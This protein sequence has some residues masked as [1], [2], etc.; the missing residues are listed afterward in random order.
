MGWNLLHQT[1][2]AMALSRSIK[3]TA[4][5]LLTPVLLAA[6]FIALFGWNWLRAPVEQMTL[7]K[8]GRQLVIGGDIKVKLGWPR[9]HVQTGAVTFANPPWSSEKQMLSAAALDITIDLSQLF[10]RHIVLPEVR[11]EHPVIFLEQGSAGRKNWLL[12]MN[13][14][15]DST[16]IRIDRLTL[17]QGQLGYDDAA[18]KTHIRAELSSTSSTPDFSGLTF[19]AHGQYK[20]LALKAQGSGGPVLGLRDESSP[21]PLKA[22]F[23]VGDTG[24]KLSGSITSL[25][26]FSALDLQLAVR[27]KNLAQLFPL[28]GIAFPKTNAYA[29]DGHLQHSGTNCRYDKFSGRIGS[30][31][32]SGKLQINTGG[33]RPVLQAQLTSKVFDLADLAPLIG[34]RPGRLQAARQAAPALPSAL[35]LAATAHVLP[36][37]PFQTERWSS[38]D[39]EVTLSASTIRRNQELPLANLNTHL[40]LRDSVLRL[41]P[42]DFGLAGGQLKAVISRDGRNDPIQAKAQVLAKEIQLAKLFPTST[43]N[44]TSIGR[45]NGELNL[46]GAG[47]SVGQ[48]LASAN[49]KVGLVVSG[50]RVSKLL[51]EEVGLH[52]WEILALN[53]TATNKS[54]CVARWPTSTFSKESCTPEPWFSTPK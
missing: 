52:L 25:L 47:N 42:L 3:W 9:P 33:K 7:E 41:D 30:S 11:L 34:T 13:Q 54:N 39:A 8:T 38:V 28:L 22:D 12:D 32:V 16:G 31:D 50:G 27:G 37:L 40:S 45:I 20:A 48:M 51:M 14:Q 18:Q 23:S 36:D 15:D 46:A 10:W 2:N 1:D 35:P 26:K 24:V 29:T 43:L 19:S 6:L 44:K 4:A 49:G 21:Y 53:L 17:D 5:L